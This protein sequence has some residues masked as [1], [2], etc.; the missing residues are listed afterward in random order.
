MGEIL[1][2]RRRNWI[3]EPERHAPNGDETAEAA[4]IG[5]FFGEDDEMCALGNPQEREEHQIAPV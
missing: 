4:D 3:K 1:G 5:D 2:R